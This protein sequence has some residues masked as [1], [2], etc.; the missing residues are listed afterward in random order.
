MWD[1]V[2]LTVGAPNRPNYFSQYFHWIV[3]Y[4]II[5]TK[6]TC[7]RCCCC[8]LLGIM[9]TLKK[10]VASNNNLLCFLEILDRASE[11]IQQADHH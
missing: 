8:S 4:A 6:N 2:S 5:I 1:V 7:D 9:E 10:K 3:D 11:G